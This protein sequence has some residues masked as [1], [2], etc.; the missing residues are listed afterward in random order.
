MSHVSHRTLQNTSY[1]MSV[2]CSSALH[3]PPVCTASL[4]SE[5]TAVV[6]CTALYG[7]AL[8]ASLY[9]FIVLWVHRCCTVYCTVRHCTLRQFVLLH[10][11]LSTPPLYCVLHC[12]ALHSPP[13]CTASLY[14][15]Y[16]AVVLCTAL[17]GIALSA[18]LYC[19]INDY[20]AMH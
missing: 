10:C 15:E 2:F 16:T 3:S 11:T 7:I 1:I 6:L 8:S 4:Y 13:V 14:S 17:Y 12:T 18:S 19:F 9:C 5:Y 20:R